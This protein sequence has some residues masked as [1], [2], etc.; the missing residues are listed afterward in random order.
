MRFSAEGWEFEAVA[1]TALLVSFLPAEK[2]TYSS[3]WQGETCRFLVGEK[4]TCF[5]VFCACHLAF[6]S[7]F[8]Y[9]ESIIA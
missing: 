1:S 3:P 7:L 4:T 6:L 5:S 9:N 8:I 2:S